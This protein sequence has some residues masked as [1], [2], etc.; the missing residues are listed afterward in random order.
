MSTAAYNVEDYS[1]PQYP[2]NNNMGPHQAFP[3]DNM[4]PIPSEVNENYWSMEDLW[5]YNGD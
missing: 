3:L 1:A 2:L 4:A 5:L